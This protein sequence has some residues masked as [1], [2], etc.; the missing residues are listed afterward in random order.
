MTA[1]RVLLLSQVRTA[2]GSITDPARTLK[3]ERSAVT[4]DVQ[5]RDI[6]L[7]AQL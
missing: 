4:R 1:K 6:H 2:P 3:R 5:A 7:N